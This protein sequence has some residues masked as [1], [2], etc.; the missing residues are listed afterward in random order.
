MKQLEEIAKEIETAKL[1][2]TLLQEINTDSKTSVWGQI[3]DVVAG[4]IF[5]LYNFFEIYRKEIRILTDRGYFGSREWFVQQ[6]KKFQYGDELK[7]INNKITYENINEKKQIV[8]Q[9]AITV[10]NKT[11]EF[12]VATSD[13][14][15]NLAPL[16]PN[17]VNSLEAYL[18]KI[19]Y[20]GTPIIVTSTFPDIIN[21]NFTIYFNA[22]L[23]RNEVEQS[24][25]KAVGDYLK[26]IVFNG[27][28]NISKCIEIIHLVDG[29]QDVF[30]N[31]ANGRGNYA[32]ES[33]AVDFSDYYTSK[34]GYMRIDNLELEMLD[35]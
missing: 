25:R 28:F 27:R 20:P 6:A 7:I 1:T 29:V 12:K 10:I 4:V 2:N 18:F 21:L 35:S 30:F 5:T 33:D 15:G 9:A 19:K 34:A 11:L 3:R 32:V 8:K 13:A 24:I 31:S 17:Q 23:K 14:G 22:T 26:S 16:T